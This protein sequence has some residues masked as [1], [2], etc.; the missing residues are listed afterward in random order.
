MVYNI[1]I[2]R[3]IIVEKNNK[4]IVN[5][6]KTCYPNV[7]ESAIYK[8]LRQK[9]IRINGVK[10][11]EN[12]PVEVGDEISV[13][14]KDEILLGSSSSFHPEWIV[15]E[16][17]NILIV[18]KPQGLLVQ[19][20]G[21]KIGLDSLINDYYGTTTIRPCHRLD[22][23]TSGLIIFA[24]DSE[25]EEIVLKLIKG[26]EISKHYR[27]LVYGHPKQKTAT[28][29]AYL[30]KDRKNN[31]VIISDEKK[32]GYVEIVTKYTV[33][34]S[35]SDGS[36]LLDVELITGRT[37]QIRAHLAYIGYPIIGDGKYGINQIN[38][39]FGKT[40][41][42]LESYKLTFKNAYGKLEYLRGK[43]FR[44]LGTEELG[45]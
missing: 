15:Y 11:S 37:H 27:C 6:I 28:L 9:N 40:W 2:M 41:Q 4:K 22:R 45:N 16:D 19:A 18:N 29:K 35:N 5:Y 33:L 12:L 32:K 10:I 26:R 36:A 31:R 13:Y 38:K 44:L 7:P 17:E 14:I 30:F 8:A 1:I 42:E 20:D 25:S 21:E 3:K 39:Q 23:N 24:K 34:Q 43:S